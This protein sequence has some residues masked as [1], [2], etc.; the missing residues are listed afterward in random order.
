MCYS[1]QLLLNIF[2]TLSSLLRL[3][4][5]EVVAWQNNEVNVTIVS[6][7]W[8]GTAAPE[9]LMTLAGNTVKSIR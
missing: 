6:A 2:P 5:T 7:K 8:L 4:M 3:P 1:M 9:L